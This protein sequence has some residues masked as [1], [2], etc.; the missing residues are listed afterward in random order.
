M[1][2]G[3][4]IIAPAVLFLMSHEVTRFVQ[5][6]RESVVAAD[7]R[8]ALV[9]YGMHPC[10]VFR[11]QS[12]CNTMSTQPVLLIDTTPGGLVSDGGVNKIRGNEG[13]R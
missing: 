7:V 4:V 9:E 13:A 6:V 3:R 2:W 5:Y 12:S 10:R 8:L 1:V 11:R